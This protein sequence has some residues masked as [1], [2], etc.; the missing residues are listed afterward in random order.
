MRQ[1][2]KIKAGMRLCSYISSL[3][4]AYSLHLL[5]IAM[6]RAPGV[7]LFT[8]CECTEPKVRYDVFVTIT[9]S[10]D[11]HSI[12]CNSFDATKKFALSKFTLREIL[13]C[14][15]GFRFHSC[16]WQLRLESESDSVRCEN[17]CIVQC[18][19]WVWNPSL[20]PSPN[21]EV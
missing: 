2:N 20:N 19:H 5:P 14:G 7:T 10:E 12:P 15:L 13:E 17:F 21:P 1:P 4:W 8:W 9:S 16:S 11:L 3:A 18:N 6:G